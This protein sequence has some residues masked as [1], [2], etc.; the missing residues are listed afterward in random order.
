M[1]SRLRE[2]IATLG[3]E[4][5]DDHPVTSDL[6]DAIDGH[7]SHHEDGDSSRKE[8]T[9]CPLHLEGRQARHQDRLCLERD[10][11][12]RETVRNEQGDFPLRDLSPRPE[13]GDGGQ[14]TGVVL[15]FPKEEKN[16]I[17]QDHRKVSQAPVAGIVCNQLFSDVTGRRTLQS[18]GSGPRLDTLCIASVRLHPVSGTDEEQHL[19]QFAPLPEAPKRGFV[20]DLHQR[21]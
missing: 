21:I 17:V 15:F 4:R 11:G 5:C 18:G 12:D 10:A 7:R 2:I 14:G 19:F 3:E 6:L 8:P 9:G 16:E 13:K 20:C 1:E